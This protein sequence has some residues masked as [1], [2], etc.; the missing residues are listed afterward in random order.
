[1][2][3]NY[4]SPTFLL[5]VEGTR[6]RSDVTDHVRGVVYEEGE[7]VVSTIQVELDNRD[8]RFNQSKA[9]LEGNS[10][11]LWMGYG[12]TLKRHGQLRFMNRCS[13][14]RP[15]PGFPR[16]GAAPTFSVEAQHRATRLL[17]ADEPSGKRYD[18]L[19]DSEI[20]ARIFAHV[21]V[22]EFAII[23]TPD[24]GA[25]AVRLRKKG[26]TFWDF[27]KNLEK[28]NGYVTEIRYDPTFGSDVV[29]F[30]PK[31]QG[32]DDRFVFHYGTGEP[33]STL[34][35]F[36]PDMGL[37]E[38]KTEIE[39]VYVDPRTRK[40][41][42]V[43]VEADPREAEKVRFKGAPGARSARQE[44]RNGPSVTV[45]V[46][47]QQ[48]KTIPD[49]QFTSPKDARR[50]AA[51]WW[52]RKEQEFLFARGTVLG[53]PSLRKGQVHTF[54][55]P[56]VRY[57]GDWRLTSVRHAMSGGSQYETEFTAAKVV[58]GSEV[59]DRVATNRV[60]LREADQ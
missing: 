45:A 37:A 3:A 56:D 52:A 30:G 42:K 20:A 21:G 51:A 29:Y 31:R 60:S 10:L 50:W 16:G 35:E 47:G 28:I 57:S 48:V 13:V 19:R 8:F 24:R 25:N 32:T 5:T 1:M 40:T 36:W 43:K 26:Q 39:V 46:L 6:L 14:V 9:F 17:M 33:D 18:G 7:D 58:L 54:V 44:L 23:T 22:G 2:D 55:L 41:R 34:L 12:G 4:L 49:R 38:T 15:N 27:I 53:E 11:D 59:T